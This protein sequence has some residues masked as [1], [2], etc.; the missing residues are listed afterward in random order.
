MANGALALEAV[1]GSTKAQAYPRTG[2]AGGSVSLRR[3]GAFRGLLM[4]LLLVWAPLAVAQSEGNSTDSQQAS[5]LEHSALFLEE[6]LAV[7]RFAESTYAVALNT[8]LGRAPTP[9]DTLWRAAIDSA[10]HTVAVALAGQQAT[11]AGDSAGHAQVATA[12]RDAYALTAR[13]YGSLGWHSRSNSYW[14]LYRQAEG[15]VQASVFAPAGLEPARVA[16]FP[17]DL[18]FATAALN[19]LGFARYEVGD[20]VSARQYYVDLIELDPDHAEAL[21]WLARMAFEEGD[22]AEA[23]Q[24][25]GRLV[26]VAPDDEGARFFLELSRE[27]EEVGVEASEAYRAGIRAY[28][29]GDLAGAHELFSSAFDHNPAFADAA[30]WAARSAF[31][32]GRPTAAQPYW[33]AALEVD[34]EDA[35]SAWFLEVTRAQIRWGVAAAN[36]FYAG[37]TVYAQNDLDQAEQLFRSAASRNPIYVDAWVWAARTSQE[38]G[39]AEEAVGLW[40]EVLRLDPSDSRAR[41]FVQLAQQ[42]LAFGPEAGEAFERGMAAYQI[43]DVEG[44]RAGFTEAVEH[45]PTFAA[46]WSQL[47]RLEFQVGNYAAAAAAYARALEIEPGNEEYE[48]FAAESRRLAGI[49]DEPQ[50]QEPDADSEQGSAPANHESEAGS[51]TDGRSEQPPATEAEP[52]PVDEA[53][54]DVDDPEPDPEPDPDDG[55]VPLPPDGGGSN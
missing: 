10:E 40:Q 16:L 45:A 4:L 2:H 26:Q 28:E 39:R 55:V 41:Y 34:P 11:A 6:F 12:L 15:Q 33:L 19:Q 9:D 27:R 43:G 46:A 44:S 14:S 38:A 20:F 52:E 18:Q 21:R 50:E 35:R 7:Y 22:T 31:E 36:D 3:A 23:M 29:A 37:Q 42:Q 13:V 51:G 47:G 17:T 1:R 49:P 25:W 48:F 24:T 32:A 53:E 54:P 8:D 30:V 5:S